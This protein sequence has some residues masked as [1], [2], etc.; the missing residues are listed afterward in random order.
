MA[1]KEVSALGGAKK[2]SEKGQVVEGK[3]VEIQTE[4]GPNESN[5]YVLDTSKGRE[6]YWGANALDPLMKNVAIGKKVRIT[7]TDTDYKFPNGRRGKNFKVE[8]EE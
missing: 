1:Y 7:C 5:I 3:L 8:I 2:F 4:V 6:S